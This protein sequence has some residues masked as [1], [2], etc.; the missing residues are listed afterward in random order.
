M[1]HG[2]FVTQRE[3]RLQKNA[4]ELTFGEITPG[5]TTQCPGHR[6]EA[7]HTQD[8]RNRIERDGDWMHA[9]MCA[10]YFLETCTCYAHHSNRR[11]LSP[12]ACDLVPARRR[13]ENAQREFGSV[14]ETCFAK[15]I[16][17][18]VRWW[19]GVPQEKKK[20]SG[21]CDVRLRFGD[22]DETRRVRISHHTPWG[23][24]PTHPRS[25]QAKACPN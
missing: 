22:S 10:C 3:P 1:R 18:S 4:P 25:H 16:F 14:V 19:S 6:P 21:E 2:D 7:A 23:V 13:W 12:A 11:I 8:P 15:R 20:K 17:L 24:H 5:L 9:L